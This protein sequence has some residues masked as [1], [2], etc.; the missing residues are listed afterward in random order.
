MN[1]DKIGSFG[2][3]ALKI[4]VAVLGAALLFK[5]VKEA[6]SDNDKEKEQAEA[7]ARAIQEA[8]MASFYR[9]YPPRKANSGRNQD[10]IEEDPVEN[11]QQRQAEE[12]A[13]NAP[14]PARPVESSVSASLRAAGSTCCQ[15][16]SVISSVSSV[17]NGIGSLFKEG[18]SSGGGN[19]PFNYGQPYFNN[20]GWPN[21]GMMYSQPL[22]GAGGPYYQQPVAPISQPMM[23]GYYPYSGNGYMSPGPRYADCPGTIYDV[24]NSGYQD[25]V[26]MRVSPNVINTQNYT[27]YDDCHSK[28]RGL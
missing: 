18:N 20:F 28:Y 3:T 6:I 4:G 25:K 22:C 16:G 11:E 8:R 15:L 23:T 1:T 7:E 5:S 21:G 10:E 26:W 17:I 2:K 27:D 12:A 9:R 14:V 24:N 13:A 19:A